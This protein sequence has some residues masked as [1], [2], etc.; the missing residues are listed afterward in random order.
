MV[1]FL[2]ALVRGFFAVFALSRNAV[3][4][5]A[6]FAPGDRIRSPEPAAILARFLWMFLYNPGFPLI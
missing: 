2:Y 6:F 1:V 4:V 3:A 5:G